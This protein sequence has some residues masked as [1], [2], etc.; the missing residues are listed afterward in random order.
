MADEYPPFRLDVGGEEPPCE[1]RLNPQ[2][3]PIH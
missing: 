1:P 2:A 3:M